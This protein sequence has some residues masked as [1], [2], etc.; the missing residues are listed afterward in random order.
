MKKF[1]KKTLYKKLLAEKEE[2]T[3]FFIHMQ[4]VWGKAFMAS[5]VLKLMIMEDTDKYIAHVSKNAYKDNEDKIPIYNAICEIH[6]R[7]CQVYSEILCLCENG[8]A[9]GAYARW[10]TLYELCVISDFISKNDK[11][12]AVSFLM[13]ENE[14]NDYQWARVAKCFNNKNGRRITFGDLQKEWRCFSE[15]WRKQYKYSNQFVHATTYGTAY[16]LG[17]KVMIEA[18]S[19][20]HSDYGISM[21]LVNSTRMLILIS[22]NLFTI[23]PSEA[24][25]KDIRRYNKWEKRIT[26]LCDKVEKTFRED[27]KPIVE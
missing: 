17:N 22:M 2:D 11:G 18:L 7:A 3:K 6:A 12:V 20:G 1:I 10:R 15:S 16:R 21:P 25:L 8:Y 9:D 27:I 14:F 23:F 13:A 24:S 26:N 19:A 5:K 4:H